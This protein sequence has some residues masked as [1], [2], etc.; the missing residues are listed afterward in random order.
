MANLQIELARTL[1]QRQ[2]LLLIA[3]LRYG[4]EDI[5]D[6]NDTLYEQDNVKG[7]LSAVTNGEIRVNGVTLAEFTVEDVRGLI[8]ALGVAA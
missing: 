8:D 2:T 1:T 5:D 6:F 7:Y 4:R 3:L